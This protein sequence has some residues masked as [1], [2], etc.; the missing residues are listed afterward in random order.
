MDD[1][2]KFPARFPDPRSP[3]EQWAAWALNHEFYFPKR[4]NA[5]ATVDTLVAGRKYRV[6]VTGETRAKSYV[7]R[8]RTED[9]AAREGMREF[10]SEC[11]GA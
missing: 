9:E 8:C 2:L 7:I 11:G 5:Q 1:I 3:R 6:N 10:V 4:V